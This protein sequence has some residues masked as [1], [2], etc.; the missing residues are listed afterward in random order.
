VLCRSDGV[1]NLEA[2][3]GG[4]NSRPGQT[5]YEGV[6][7]ISR[8][9]P[10]HHLP[11][12]TDACKAT[13]APRCSLCGAWQRTMKTRDHGLP[14]QVNVWLHQIIYLQTPSRTPTRFTRTSCMHEH[15]SKTQPITKTPDNADLA[16]GH[17]TPLQ[18]P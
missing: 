2:E 10:S 14:P 1:W 11:S 9:Q 6:F 16:D 8:F 4:D 7:K 15:F 17:I 3:E 13:M 18:R 5:R 12:Q